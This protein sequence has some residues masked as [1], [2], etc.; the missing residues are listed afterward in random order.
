M[1][2]AVDYESHVVLSEL[3]LRGDT[4]PAPWVSS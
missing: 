3:F 4:K 2:A 1:S